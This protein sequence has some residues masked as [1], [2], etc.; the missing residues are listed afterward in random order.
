[1]TF[2]KLECV[3]EDGNI[4]ENGYFLK[5]ENAEKAKVELDSC[6]INIKYGIKQHII[7]I[8]TED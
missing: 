6:K 5:P 2:Y 1:M 3:N 4:E 8:Q 7:T